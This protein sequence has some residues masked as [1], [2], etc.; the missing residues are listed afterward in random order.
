MVISGW[1]L[2]KLYMQKTSLYLAYI[3]PFTLTLTGK[4]EHSRLPRDVTGKGGHSR[5]TSRCHWE[6]WKSMASFP[7]ASLPDMISSIIFL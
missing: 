3:F 6:G 1:P 5:P 7:M 4:G 2:E